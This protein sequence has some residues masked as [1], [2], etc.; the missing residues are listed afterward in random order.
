MDTKAL[1]YVTYGMYILGTMDGARPTGCAVNTVI[2]AASE[3]ALV[4]VCVNHDNYTNQCIKRSGGF[5]VSILSE[6]APG[7]LI[8]AFGF[9][10]G[11]TDDK[12][13]DIDYEAAP[14]GNPVLKSGVCGWIECRVTGFTDLKT[15]TVFFG[16]V[17]GTALFGGTPMTYAYYHDVVKGKTAKNAPTYEKPEEAADTAPASETWVCPI[18]GYEYTGSDFADL[19]DDWVCPICGAPKSSF[20][21]K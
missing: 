8:G 15:H 16:E 17:T 13:A 14:G 9:R 3:P 10:S 18:C 12:F 11:R 1:R 2:Q 7:D 4:A 6:A 21:K 20:Q 5:A 19:P